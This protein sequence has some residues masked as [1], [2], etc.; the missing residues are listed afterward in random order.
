[1]PYTW[2][3]RGPTIDGGFGVCIC[4]PG[5]AITSVPN[6]TLRNSQLMNGTSM[7]SPHAAGVVALLLSALTQQS[8]P[9]SPY[10][11]KR[12]LENGAE[13]LDGIE[14]FAQGRGLLQLENSYKILK[15]YH[16]FQECNVR[17][18]I[19]CGPSSTKGIYLRS[20]RRFNNREFSISVEPFFLNQ[21]QVNP[22]KKIN[23]NIKV[24]LVSKASYVTCPTHLDLSNLARVFA[25]KV[26]TSSLPEGVHH[27]TV[28]AFDTSCIGKGPIFRIPVTI[29]IPIEVQG[30]RYSCYYDN[31][32][33]LANTIKRQFYLVPELAT[34]ATIQ[35]RSPKPQA[36]G[37]FF[38][39]CMQ[40]LPKQS[41]KSMEI[42][43]NLSVTDTADTIIS[44][45]V[46][47]G[48]ILEVALAKYWADYGEITV[49]YGISFHGIKPNLPSI[50]MQSVDGIQTVE[51]TSM[52]G[53]DIAPA[54][55]LKSAVQILK[56]KYSLCCYLFIF[57]H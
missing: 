45:Q 28:D 34:W 2:S 47:G 21:D 5:G 55:S 13:Y 6:F 23:F 7:A 15:N 22:S 33:F 17:F 20:R 35:I 40:L 16:H 56:Y 4:A 43:K 18:N 38:I 30:P 57:K 12:A 49:N 19:C 9:Y 36:F 42:N 37:R 41:C 51:V 46:K 8:I 53:E 3:S 26:D 27:T 50:T 1:M 14:P 48:L 31:V 54:V 25:V 10:S 52:C 11:V 44:L 39:H 29:V 32:I 24:V